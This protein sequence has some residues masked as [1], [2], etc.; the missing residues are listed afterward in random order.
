MACHVTQDEHMSAGEADDMADPALGRGAQEVI[1]SAIDNATSIGDVE[2][3]VGG[4]SGR[5]VQRILVRTR[6]DTRPVVLKRFPA[7]GDGAAAEWRALTAIEHVPVPS[8]QPLLWDRD[9]AWFGEPAIVMSALPGTVL[10]QVPRGVT[11]LRNATVAMARLHAIPLATVPAGIPAWP[12]LLDRWTPDGLPPALGRASAEVIAELRHRAIAARQ[13][14]C[15]GDFYL[16]NLLF[17]GQRLTGI[18]D[19]ERAKVMPPGNEVA[20]FR[21]DLAIHPGGGAPGV[22]LNAYLQETAIPAV[23]DL[24]LWDVLAG[25]VGLADAEKTRRGLEE[26]GISLGTATVTRR[27]RIFLKNAVARTVGPADLNDRLID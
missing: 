14:L 19:W 3:L 20:R 2:R 15:H 27:A 22:F 11:W 8:P 10:R 4:R 16:G 18:V 7:D 13:A 12:R 9:G 6:Y 5:P 1:L 26:L 17:A 25:A 21:M 23:E 24:A